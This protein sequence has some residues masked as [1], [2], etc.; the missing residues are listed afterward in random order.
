[1]FGWD[2]MEIKLAETSRSWTYIFYFFYKVELN[3]HLV[4]VVSYKMI[5]VQILEEVIHLELFQ[6]FWPYQVVDPIHHNPIPEKHKKWS[7]VLTS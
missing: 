3:L 5:S 6:L 2:N 7:R 4:G 1:M